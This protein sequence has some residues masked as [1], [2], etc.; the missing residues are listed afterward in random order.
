MRPKPALLAILALCWASALGA[1]CGG[2]IIVPGGDGSDGGGG[3]GGGGVGSQAV[4]D[5]K[6]CAHA[7]CKMVADVCSCETTCSGPKLRADCKMHDGGMLICECHYNGGYMGTCS[8][9][10]GALCGL[11][12]GC[13]E[14]YVP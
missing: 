14:A 8:P 2:K 7:D 4:G 13:C 5:P 11:P 3:S 1:A 10:G 12:D 6:D 9:S